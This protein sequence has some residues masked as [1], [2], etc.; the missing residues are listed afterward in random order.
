[1]RNARLP[2][3]W[4]DFLLN[5]CFSL[6]NNNSQTAED[7]A[8]ALGFFE[9]AQFLMKVKQIQ[10]KKAGAQCNSSLH[11]NDESIH[12]DDSKM[13]KGVCERNRLVNR[14]RRRSSGKYIT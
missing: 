5:V 8:L 3:K 14:K 6:R 10:N 2:V 11:D 12:T 1:M 4:I 7:L 13:Q 9:C